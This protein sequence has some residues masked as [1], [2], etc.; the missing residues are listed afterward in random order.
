M[1]NKD[2]I[3]AKYKELRLAMSRAV[4]EKHSAAIGR[5]LLDE[6]DWRAIKSLHVYQ[7]MAKLNEVDLA[8]FISVIKSRYRGLELTSVAAAKNQ[9]LPVKQFDLIIVPIL[10][11]DKAKHR[12]GWGGG[13]YDRFLASQ[14]RALKIGVSFENGLVETSLPGQAHDIRL[15]KII[16][17]QRTY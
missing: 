3:R 6:I 8:N 17:E 5:R 14:P 9:P 1:V 16:T 4:V 13:W 12:L 7:P 10:A 15:D 2:A 11:F